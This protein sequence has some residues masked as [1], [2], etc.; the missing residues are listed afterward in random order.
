VDEARAKL[1]EFLKK[2]KRPASIMIVS[3]KFS[4]PWDMIYPIRLIE[5]PILFENFWGMNH[6]IRRLIAKAYKGTNVDGCITSPPK[7]GLLID[8]SLPSV[9]K[10]EIRFFKGLA[11][12][13]LIFLEKLQ[14]LDPA[15]RLVELSTTY[16][17]FLGNP[18]N[19]AHFACHALYEDGQ[20]SNIK[21][22]KNFYISLNDM[23][24]H[25]I[26][27]SGYPL[28]VLNACESGNLNPLYTMNFVDDFLKR[29]AIGVVATE[30]V[31]PDKFAAL[32]AKKLYGYLL[33]ERED[34]E[35]FPLGKSLLATRQYFLKE[36]KNPS[37]LIYSMYAPP[38]IRFGKRCA[39]Q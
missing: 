2:S 15:Q 26:A 34:Q 12:N 29:G 23:Q 38:S 35:P 11:D 16:K 13:G 14:E 28:I 6:I 27:L 22:S 18:L 19:I 36:E 33:P 25:E 7:L 32:F 5:Q 20:N 30:C 4:L 8:S 3:A 10:E 24:A 17:N 31:I 9:G 21:L 37:G 1:Q 39:E